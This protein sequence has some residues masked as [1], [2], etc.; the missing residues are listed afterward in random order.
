MRPEMERRVVRETGPHSATRETPFLDLA[1]DYFEFVPRE[2]ASS[3][4]GRPRVRDRSASSRIGRSTP[5][6]T[7]I[8]A[9]A[10]LA[11]SRGR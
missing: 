1:P 8:K 9:S 6:T 5:A 11:S 3:R 7:P 10:K 2:L 4:T